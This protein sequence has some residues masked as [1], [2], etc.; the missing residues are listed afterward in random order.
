MLKQIAITAVI[1]LAAVAIVHR[2]PAARKLVT[3]A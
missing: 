2:V 3:G 1:A